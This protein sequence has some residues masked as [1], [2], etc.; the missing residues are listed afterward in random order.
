MALGNKFLYNNAY[1]FYTIGVI[2]L[3]LVLLFGKEVNNAK[4]WFSIPFIG[5][6]QPSEFM[7]IFLIIALSRMI[8]D[9]NN[10]Y[11][12]PDITEEFKFLIQENKH[13]LANTHNLCH[14]YR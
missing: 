11:S 13:L 1:I 9:F 7:K 2:S 14:I 4:C 6:L 5:T 8:T 12:N 10:K 3:I